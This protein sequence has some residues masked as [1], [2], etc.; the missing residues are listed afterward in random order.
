MGKGVSTIVLVAWI[1][2]LAAC[3]GPKYTVDDGRKVNEELL[4]YI[5]AYGA[6]ER[7]LRPAI[8]RSASLHDP[9]CSLQWELPFAV[10]SSY[11]WSEDD[12]VAWVRALGV[13]ERLTVIAVTPDS[14]LKPGQK[15]KAVEG[16]RN[17]DNS[18]L[19]ELMGRLRDRGYPFDVTLF[20]ASVVRVTPFQACRGYTRLAPPSS[21]KAQDYH[22]LMSV[23]PLEVAQV[24][25]TDDE[26]L[27]AVLWTQG[28]SE[29]GGVR[30]KAYSYST[31][32]A[33]T[34][35]NLF[36][37][38]SGIKG[39]ALAADAAVKAAQSAA[40][41]AA[42]EVVKQQLINQA[43]SYAAN[44]VRDQLSEVAQK[45]TQQQ[46]M[47]TMQQAAANRGSLS[48]VAWVAS[49]VFDRADAWAYTRMG[50]LNAN[51]LAGLSLH[52]KLVEQ[53]WARNAMVFDPE[54][55][56]AYNKMAQAQGLSAE[57]TAILQGIKAED[58]QA[59]LLDMPLA[60]APSAFSYD[61]L[62]ASPAT[63]QQPYARGFVDGMLHSPYD[64]TS[65]AQ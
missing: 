58:L 5:K 55:L 10:A 9:D 30:M 39:A 23:H 64:I 21:P 63:A 62:S 20:D 44:K 45:L 38:T 54:R 51:P 65:S 50:R 14:P 24:S 27:W 18:Y 41:A 4:G 19:I 56:A 17:Q 28:I 43:S 15:I 3:S 42:T 37:I 22:W 29:E 40:T 52:Q 8:A 13:D 49:T 11:D 25:L 60:T 48:G 32:V 59:P 35:Y 33:G 2:L 7:A 57:V 6:G 61:D 47:N 53:G 16:A 46:V 26:A 1:S 34:L 12:R 36:T 31:Q